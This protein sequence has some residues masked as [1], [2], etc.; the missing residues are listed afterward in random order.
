MSKLPDAGRLIDTSYVKEIAMILGNVFLLKRIFVLTIFAMAAF[1]FSAAICPAQAEKKEAVTFGTEDRET[2]VKYYQKVEERYVKTVAGLSPEQLA[3]RPHEKSWTVGQVAEHLLITE[4]AVR[5]MID[6][7]VLKTPLNKD[8][9]VFRFADGAI[10]LAVTNRSQK[11]QAPP[12]VQPK[13][14]VTTAD[15]LVSG[16]KEARANNVEFLK[17]TEVDLRNHF[18]ENPL[19]GTIDA[20]Q[21]FLFLNGHTERHLA[22]IDEIMSHKDY[23]RKSE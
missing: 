22:Q 3:F 1:G 7:G 2:I 15:G 14:K 21:W 12:I 20:Y 18:A 10:T 6:A 23:P 4:S 8:T 13:A 5:G 16:F 17:T 19:F 9:G 11:F